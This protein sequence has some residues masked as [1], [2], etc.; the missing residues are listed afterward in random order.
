MMT[1]AIENTL[2]KPLDTKKY[3]ANNDVLYPT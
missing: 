1:K 2:W 3:K